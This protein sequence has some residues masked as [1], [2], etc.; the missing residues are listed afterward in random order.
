MKGHK[1]VGCES[2]TNG[3]KPIG[4]ESDMNDGRRSCRGSAGGQQGVSRG[5]AGG[6]QGVCRGS[7]TRRL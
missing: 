1:P 3:H 4:C 2:D 7:Q 6:Q 5:L